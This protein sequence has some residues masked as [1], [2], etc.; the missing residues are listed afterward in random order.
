MLQFLL[1]LI[2]N[3]LLIDKAYANLNAE[4]FDKSF[5]QPVSLSPTIVSHLP[6][7]QKWGPIIFNYKKEMK[8]NSPKVILKD[9]E[10]IK[11][12]EKSLQDI[13]EFSRCVSKI[14]PPFANETFPEIISDL[15][16]FPDR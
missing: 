13:L 16:N 14:I 11:D 6:N 10:I 7:I 12:K 9:I 3:F 8:I 4:I 1:P 5:I 15:I 2:F